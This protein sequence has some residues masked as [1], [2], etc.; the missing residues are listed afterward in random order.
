MTLTFL[1]LVVVSG[2]LVGLIEGSVQTYRERSTGDVIISN[3]KEKTYIDQ[4]QAI[5]QFA[6]NL[7]WVEAITPRYSDSGVIEAGYQTRINQTDLAN[8]AGAVF[9]GINPTAENAVTGL[10]DLVTEGSYLTA[11][12]YD[13][14]V[15]GYQLLR[16][17]LPIDSPG[18]QLLDNVDVGDK[19][20]IKINGTVREVTIK[21]I[22]KAKVDDVSRR[23]YFVDTQLR[24]L[25]EA[26]GGSSFG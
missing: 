4:S 21:G 6:K 25:I 16:K 20:R 14:V 13:Q 3:L 26:G 12:D 23:V 8:E 18:L 10:G 24:G 22:I 2:I 11:T 17:Y 15:I 1:N 5:I 19:V 7:P 9:T